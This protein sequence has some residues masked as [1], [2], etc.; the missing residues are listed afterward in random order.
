[1]FI[2]FYPL[3]TVLVDCMLTR[4]NFSGIHECDYVLVDY[5]LLCPFFWYDM[6]HMEKFKFFLSS[7]MESGRM[8][9]NSVTAPGTLLCI[10]LS[11]YSLKI[12]QILMARAMST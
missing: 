8:T 5:F 9:Q 6:D 10:R 12:V 11:D 2:T 1:M 3:Q 4:Y 7:E